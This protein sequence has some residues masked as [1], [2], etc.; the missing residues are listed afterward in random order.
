MTEHDVTET[1][2]RS[3]PEGH[4]PRQVEGGVQ[5]RH[6]HQC[7]I[8]W[9]EQVLLDLDENNPPRSGQSESHM[10]AGCSVTWRREGDQSQV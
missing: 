3:F 2:E 8:E 9:N 1:T 6:G 10:G 5:G 4:L 7:P